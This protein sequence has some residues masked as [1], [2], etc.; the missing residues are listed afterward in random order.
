LPTF[1]IVFREVIEA[2][3]IVGIVLAASRGI[4]GRALW[5]GYGIA[6]GVAGAC[7]VALFASQLSTLFAGNGQEL[8]NAAILI[9]AVGML[10]WHNAWM[11]SHGREM[12]KAARALGTAVAEGEQPL[13]ALAIVVGIAVLR[14][15]SEVVLFLYGIAAASHATAGA[16]LTGGMLGILGG[17]LLSALMYAGLVVIPLKHLFTVTG[18][19]IMLLAAGLAAQAVAFLQQADY[20][21]TWSESLWNTS[22]I[23]DENSIVGRVLHTLV[24]YT[25]TPDTAQLVA[26]LATI[27]I[28]R[29]CM[30]LAAHQ[31]QV[32]RLVAASGQPA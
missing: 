17:V 9:L 24:G 28:M 25:A 3:I 15:G 12:A 29:G 14:E 21:T 11:A 1:I 30:R 6:G 22:R 27:V 31:H 7:L 2:G 10:T 4:K 26:Y 32:R 19:L 8:F 16:M 13:T 5:I 23:L 20:L 18:T